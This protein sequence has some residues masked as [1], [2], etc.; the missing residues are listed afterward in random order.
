MDYENVEGGSMRKIEFWITYI[1]SNYYEADTKEQFLEKFD[2]Y[3]DA[4]KYILED[5]EYC[6]R[7]DHLHIR[8]VYVKEY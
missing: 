7:H 4:E 6:D 8:K 3:E 5:R 1:D 2:K